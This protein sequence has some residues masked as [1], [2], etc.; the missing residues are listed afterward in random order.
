MA[1]RKPTP[2]FEPMDDATDGA[3]V[4]DTPDNE[5]PTL[6][7]APQA[8]PT[9]VAVA[10]TLSLPKVGGKYKPAL[11]DLMNVISTDDLEAMGASV[12][13]RITADLGGLVVDRKDELG[14]VIK[15]E[16]VSWNLRYVITPGVVDAE[17]NEKVRMSYDGVH[18]NGSTE[19]VRDYLDALK[20]QGYEK[21]DIKLYGDLWC[22][23]MA[24]DKG[25]LDP[26]SQ[27]MVQVQM[28]PQTLAKFKAFQ[29]EQ[30]I[31]E[32]RG[33]VAPTS[34]LVIRAES[35]TLGSNR[36]GIMTFA[37]K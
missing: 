34:V 31:K 35:K 27:R 17:A 16:V 36:F 21:A 6:N 25:E 32:A 22:T 24:T 7:D 33:L 19:M 20:A 3:T 5:S 28:S 11:A 1:L 30:G 10:P 37:T 23:L 29:L 26:E 2:G 13:P 14:K 18:L 15:V 9:P 8:S 4:I 12:F